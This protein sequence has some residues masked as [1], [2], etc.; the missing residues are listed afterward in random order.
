[1]DLSS[2][3]I[4]FRDETAENLRVY[5]QGLMALE[6]LA[7]DDEGRRPEI[8]AIFRAMHTIKGSAR[9]LGFEA[10]GR[11]AHTC[12][13]ILGAVREGR[14]DLDRALTDDLLKG[15]DAI[16][17]LVSA[18][19]DGRPSGMDVEAFAN[20]LGRGLPKDAEN[21]P[22]PVTLAPPIDN[23]GA[24]QNAPMLPEAPSAVLGPQPSSR[25]ARA[26]QT[27]RV[28]VDR[29]D[30]LL[31]LA[32][33][34]TVGRQSHAVHLQALQELADLIAHQ[35]RTLLTLESD[36]RRLRFS[37]SQREGL[38]GHLNGM[39]NAGERAGRIIKAQLERFGQYASASAQ[40]VE[41][42]EQEVMAVR[43]L[44]IST[45]FANLP[46]AVREL[47]RDLGR[48]VQLTLAGETTEL[49]RKVIEALGD[50]LTHL[51]R[52]ALDHGI[53]PPE[54]RERVGKPRQGTI[55]VA[56]Q[57][58]GSAAQITIRDDGRGMDPQKLRD[59]AVRKGLLTADAAALL[60][61]QEAIELVFLPG[62]T[63]ARLITDVSGRGVG[64]DVVRT[65][66]GEL[67]GQVQIESQFGA[68]ATIR[69]ILPLTLVT[70]RVLLVET[71]EHLFGVPA[72]GCQGSL[73]VRPEKI[74]TV[75]GRA[76]IQHEGGLVPVVRLDGL[77]ELGE[78]RPLGSRRIPALL[79]GAAKRPLAVIVDRMLDER[80]VVVKP[81][82]PL[83]EKQRRYSGAIQLG[84]GRLAL[85]LN[86]MALAQM[87]RGAAIAAPPARDG[88]VSRH[89][90]LVVD[91]A[92][93]T[94]EL[95]RSILHSAGYDVTTAVD[96]LD[97][98]DKL[99]AASYDLV[100]SDVEMPRV[101]GFTLTS[102][103][104]AEIGHTG[105]P[106]IIMTSLASEQ[107]R[108]RG[109]E[110]GAQAYIVKSQFNQSN[111]LETIRQLLGG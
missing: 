50:P 27:V 96:G 86:P 53:E 54:E 74:R 72:T 6:T 83:M 67:G 47:A 21:A 1:M 100:V 5:T 35:E 51:L 61:D 77:L 10:I 41:D 102:R 99:K 4:Q 17:E 8:D 24:L 22:P 90:L 34:L 56:A 45:L 62:F 25:R 103:I 70:T 89:H 64:M 18:A 81:L 57:A 9:L 109:L 84:D 95:I 92:F 78:P 76:M 39:L 29:L 69:L 38:D 60:S 65:N 2:F 80:E 97:A 36:L 26:R 52:N 82:G 111:L 73:W 66:I 37:Q 91:D 59:A 48:E 19:V 108:R 28:R 3:H 55:E 63:T 16:L 105:L 75:E 30:K 12:E 101:D 104:R 88:A 94:R 98:L 32:G 33:E 43:L 106:V 110:V 107:H 44:P 40:L 42:L 14:R 20:R 46:R 13:H 58:L 79:I 68:G 15:G 71:G 7:P 23:G 11:I 85:L 93:A 31:N 49:D 87:T